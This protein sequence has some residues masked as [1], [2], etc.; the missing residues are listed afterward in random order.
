MASDRESFFKASS[1]LLKNN[2]YPI[3]QIENKINHILNKK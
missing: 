3:E 2:I 1:G